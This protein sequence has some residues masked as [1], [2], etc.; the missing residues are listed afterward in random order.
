MSDLSKL[1]I[2]SAHSIV[3]FSDKVRSKS[4]QSTS[5]TLK[6]YFHPTTTMSSSFVISKPISLSGSPVIVALTSIS[7]AELVSFDRTNQPSSKAIVTSSLSQITSESDIFCPSAYKTISSINS[8]S[9]SSVCVNLTDFI[10]RSS[11][12]LSLD[13]SNLQTKE[14]ASQI[15]TEVGVIKESLISNFHIL[16]TST[17]LTN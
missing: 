7:I 12:L 1:A 4:V 2:I 13:I 8:S 10:Y 9:I 17:I 3:M 5:S 15:F 11:F 16:L 6:P 14:S